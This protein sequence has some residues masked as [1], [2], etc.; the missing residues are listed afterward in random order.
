MNQ[1]LL[2]IESDVPIPPWVQWLKPEEQQLMYLYRQPSLRSLQIIIRAQIIVQ[3]NKSLKGMKELFCSITGRKIS[4]GS[5]QTLKWMNKK[6]MWRERSKLVNITR[7]WKSER[8]KDYF[9]SSEKEELQT[10]KQ[11]QLKLNDTQRFSRISANSSKKK[12]ARNFD[13]FYINIRIP[14]DQPATQHGSPFQKKN[15]V[16]R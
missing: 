11:L 13:H 15:Y 8:L 14:A 5:I 7:V 2:I 16:F 6:H 3:E 1:R 10:T 9:D 4:W 12:F